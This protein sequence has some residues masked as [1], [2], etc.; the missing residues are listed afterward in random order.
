MIHNSKQKLQAGYGCEDVDPRGFVSL[1]DLYE[2]NFL[3]LR[4]LIPDLP[5]IPSHAVSSL[6]G[7]L[8]L[9]MDILEQTKFTTTLRLTYY[10]DDESS[11]E[12]IA[13]P[14][15]TVRVYHDA[16]QVEVLTG[17]LR[18]GRL[19]FT[20][21]PSETARVKWQL[22][23]FLYKWLGYCLYLG[24]A[25]TPESSLSQVPVSP[26]SS[27]ACSASDPDLVKT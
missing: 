17:H 26:E 24:H 8:S 9:H 1:M 3:R 22:N 18:H 27:L 14:Q 11:D 6:H 25:F 12:S 13:E 10:F 19:H 23:R 21:I 2:N 7:C 20:N 16:N 4:R 15:L 5:S